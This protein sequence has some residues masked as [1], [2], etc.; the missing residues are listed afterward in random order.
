MFSMALRYKLS[1]EPD[2]QK[3]TKLLILRL[4]V[5]PLYTESPDSPMGS[6]SSVNIWI[7]SDNLCGLEIV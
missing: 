7:V 2:F 6:L 3:H 5:T 1:N 4:L